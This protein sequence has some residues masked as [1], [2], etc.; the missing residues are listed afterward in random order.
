MRSVQRHIRNPIPRIRADGIMA[1]YLPLALPKVSRWPDKSVTTRPQ[2]SLPT[3]ACLGD[4]SIKPKYNQPAA[5]PIRFPAAS[6]SSAEALPPDI[7]A[8]PKTNPAA[9]ARTPTTKQSIM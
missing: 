7:I 2:A 6:K 5:M 4:D 8:A 1:K 9:N 3:V